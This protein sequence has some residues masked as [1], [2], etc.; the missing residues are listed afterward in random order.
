MKEQKQ[1]RMLTAQLDSFLL[2]Q[3]DTAG[4]LVLHEMII[5]LLNLDETFHYGGEN[6]RKKCK[7][8]TIPSL[9]LVS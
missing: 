7:Y 8:K 3:Q 5:E 9:L 2:Q 4:T 6:L 1:K